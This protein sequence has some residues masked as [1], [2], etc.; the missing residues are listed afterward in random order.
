MA[1]FFGLFDY[2][3]EGAGVEKNAPQKRAWV[4]FFEIYGRKFW[5]LMQAGLL[6][7]L[8]SLPVVT[9]G[10]AQVGLT[11]VTRNFSR[12]KH[13]FVRADFFETIRK[14]RG[15]ALACGL[16]NLVV[17]G[18]L[19]F[20]ISYYTFGLFPE[21]ITLFDA[22]QTVPEPM[23]MG[24]LN[25]I[26]FG[27]SVFGYV[28]FTFMKYYIPFLVVTFRL[29]LKQIYRNALIFSAA[30]LKQNLL[31]SAVLLLI[32]IAAFLLLALLPYMI[33]YMLV[34]LLFVLVL[35]GFRSLLIQY[36]IFPVIR[37]LM[38]DPYYAEHPDAD[39]QQ[40]LD[41]NLEVEEPEPDEP[42]F[43]DQRAAAAPT[44]IPRQ[45]SEEE[46]RQHGRRQTQNDDE[47]DST[48]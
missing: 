24:L 42:I 18:L 12:Q 16:I 10:W 29:S 8:V 46:L 45:Y 25:Y 7:L 28:V 33:V 13:A 44:T 41:L 43:S 32:Y 34:L 11:F 48:I 40:R 47:D 38:I 27:V 1:G 14:N 4:V 35:P 6:Y 19:L 36:T 37:R 17:T 26:V 2:T 30:G 9:C 22:S 31:I 39:K 20:N 21:L 15:Q 5:Q 23:K 3:K